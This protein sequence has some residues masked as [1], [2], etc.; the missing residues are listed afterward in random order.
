MVGTGG[1]GGGSTG[2]H[3]HRD[4]GS[5]EAALGLTQ[6]TTKNKVLHFF[7]VIC[8]IDGGHCKLLT[9]PGIYCCSS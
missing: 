3:G 1:G 9:A 8:S 5:F 4:G 7:Q 6:I 2:L